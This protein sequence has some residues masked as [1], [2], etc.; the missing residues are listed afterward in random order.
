DGAQLVADLIQAA[1]NV[2]LMTTS[3]ERLNLRGE[4]VYTLR[5]LDFPTWE[6]P[7]DALQYDAVKLFMQSAHRV[8]PDFELQARDLDFLARICRL[9]AGM[10]LGIELAAG[11]VDVLS[12]EQIATEIQQG[13]DILETEMRDV[14]ERQRSIRATF[15]WT[16]ERLTED[17]KTAFMRLS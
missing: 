17:E 1:P 12:L 8:R 2:R 5:G 15:D 7:D 4:T 6:T 9:T 10:P 11:W 16:W 14:P 13:I 3:R